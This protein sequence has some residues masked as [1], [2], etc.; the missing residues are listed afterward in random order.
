MVM[1]KMVV[2][3]DIDAE[4]HWNQTL[5]LGMMEEANPHHFRSKRREEKKRDQFCQRKSR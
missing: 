5:S 2:T 4:F 1:E 3:V